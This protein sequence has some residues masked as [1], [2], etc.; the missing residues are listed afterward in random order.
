M[1]APLRYPLLLVALVLISFALPRALPGDPLAVLSSGG[2]QDSPIVLSDQARAKLSAYYGLNQPLP[3]QL[4]HFL[5]ETARGDL[6]FSISFNR[7]VTELLADRAPWTLLLVGTSLVLATVFGTLM[8]LAAAWRNERRSQ[9]W[10]AA[11][12]MLLGSLPEFVAG[13]LLILLLVVWLRVLPASGALT[14]FTSCA[15]PSGLAGCG[16]DVLA[17]AVL[18]VL[19]LSAA[20]LPA[21]F[22]VMRATTLS[23]RGQPYVLAA[24]ARGLDERRVALRH[25]GRN[26]ILPVITLLGLRLGAMLGGVVVVETLFAYPGLGRLAFQAALARD[27]PLLQALLLLSG[28]S[29]LVLNALADLA[30]ARIDPRLRLETVP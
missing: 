28:L 2:G 30:R 22:L 10:L 9:R 20:Q 23:E 24:R 16:A 14:P 1:K 18:P 15:G 12:L 21:F 19:A 13:I 6:G 5:A 17:H 4:G 11:G 3:R 27:F 25:A 8:G 29:I 26:A 7:P